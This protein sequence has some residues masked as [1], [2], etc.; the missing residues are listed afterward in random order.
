MPAK[1]RAQQRLFGMAYAVKKGELSLSQV[2]EGVR[3]QVKRMVKTMSKEKLREFA[4]TPHKRLPE[5]KRK[6]G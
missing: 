3:E 2:P 5:R 1:S 4:A 6:K